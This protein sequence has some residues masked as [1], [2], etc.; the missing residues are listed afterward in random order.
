M[1]RPPVKKRPTFK[2]SPADS[3]TEA[4]ERELDRKGYSGS[5]GVPPDSFLIVRSKTPIK[6]PTKKELDRMRQRQIIRRNPHGTA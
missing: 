2:Q 4:L 5:P 3:A 1:A 6:P